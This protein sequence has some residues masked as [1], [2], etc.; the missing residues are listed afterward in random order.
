VLSRER[1][2]LVLG[3]VHK[4]GRAPFANART[5]TEAILY[6]GGFTPTAWA[7]HVRLQRTIEGSPAAFSVDVTRI[8]EGEEP[9]LELDAGDPAFVPERI[10]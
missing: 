1:W 3:Q 10:F 8:L 6:S 7:G 2:V 9:D 4:P 5:I